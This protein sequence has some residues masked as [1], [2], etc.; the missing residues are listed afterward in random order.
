MPGPK[1]RLV[2]ES[3]PGLCGLQKLKGKYVFRNCEIFHV[4][5]IAS[6]VAQKRNPVDVNNFQMCA[7]KNPI[8]PD[9][10]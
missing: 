2:Q 10:G 6:S 1:L 8:S 7:V 3:A 4:W 5:H 9:Y